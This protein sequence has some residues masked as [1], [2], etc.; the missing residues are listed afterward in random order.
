MLVLAVGSALLLRLGEAAFLPKSSIAVAAVDKVCFRAPTKIGDTLYLESEI[1]RLTE[2]DRKRGLIVIHCEIK[3]QHG[4]AVVSFT[5]KALAGR[6]PFGS[7]AGQV[8][9]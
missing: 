6:K 2:V 1:V 5:A 9:Q 4:A 3:N 7:V 8:S